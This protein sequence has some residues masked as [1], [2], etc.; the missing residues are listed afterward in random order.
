MCSGTEQPRAQKEKPAVTGGGRSKQLVRSTTT[1]QVLM[2][3]SSSAPV[4]TCSHTNE[5]ANRLKTPF[6]MHFPHQGS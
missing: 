6:L 4:S 5:Q 1:S 2:S 3:Q